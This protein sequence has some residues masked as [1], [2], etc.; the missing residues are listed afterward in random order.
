MSEPIT[1]D[2]AADQ[3]SNMLNPQA[4]T[5][6]PETPEPQAEVAEPETEEEAAEPDATE[7]S[8]ETEEES[9]EEKPQPVEIVIDGEKLSIE[10]IKASRLRHAD[11]TRKTQELADNRKQLE[12]TAAAL[13]QERELYAQLL[14]ALQAQLQEQEPDWDK[15]FEQDPTNAPKE[16]VKYQQRKEAARLA[17]AEAE[18]VRQQQQ[19]ETEQQYRARLNDEYGKLLKAVPEWTNPDK[20]KADIQKLT[21]VAKQFGFTDQ[22]LNGFTDHRQ[23]L[24]LRAAAQSMDQQKRVQ[25]VKAATPQVA[26]VKPGAKAAPKKVDEIT[27]GKQRLAKTG[28]VED[29]A[30]ILLKAGI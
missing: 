26:V 4:D 12:E 6:Q 29:L 2:Q 3:I 15:L 1:L 19:T 16:Y 25:A 20:Y 22:E 5:Q 28:R 21:D 8:A 7:E 27:V 9:Q 11:Y 17:A 14:P 13:R 10:E 30:D 18:R 23:I 24:V